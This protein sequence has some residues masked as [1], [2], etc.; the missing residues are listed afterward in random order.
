[1]HIF[2]IPRVAFPFVYGYDFRSSPRDSRR[3]RAE[4]P[5]VA[6]AVL[7]LLGQRGQAVQ[8]FLGRL[9]DNAGFVLP[10]KEINADRLRKGR[11][12]AELKYRRFDS[13]PRCLFAG[14]FLHT[15]A[16]PETLCVR[17]AVRSRVAGDKPVATVPGT[18]ARTAV[19]GLVLPANTVYTSLT[20]YS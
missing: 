11:Q 10:Q 1:M 9:F 8:L 14:G 13:S 4:A 17:I 18:S 7:V 19:T 16:D 3:R 2:R 12:L 20:I 15:F 6:G 5:H